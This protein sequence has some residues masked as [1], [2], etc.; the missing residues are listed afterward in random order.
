MPLLG[1]P[2]DR[3]NAR[4]KRS[5]R[6]TQLRLRQRVAPAAAFPIDFIKGHDV[7]VL[8]EQR[9]GS[10][11]SEFTQ[12]GSLIINVG[13]ECGLI[14]EEAVDRLSAVLDRKRQYPCLVLSPVP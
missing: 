12:Y 14:A 7:A 8:A 3:T 13:L 4:Y 6:G 1:R 2:H 9:I 5:H 11:F 10:E